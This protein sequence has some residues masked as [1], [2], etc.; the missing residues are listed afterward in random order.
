M[1]GHKTLKNKKKKIY[2]I[3]PNNID[4]STFFNDLNYILKSK[5]ISFF[6]LRLKN[7]KSKKI[8]KYAFKIRKLCQK[9]NVKF[10]INDDPEMSKNIGADGCHIGQR[11]LGINSA[12]KILG[13]KKIL[14]ITCHNSIRLVKKAISHKG[15]VD[16]IAIGAFFKSRTKK[17]KYFAKIE[18][19]KEIRK[20]TK[21]PIVAIG[22]I[23]SKNYKT[24]LLNKVDFLAISGDIWKNKKLKPKD[25]I[26]KFL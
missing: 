18:I 4:S 7:Q 15:K 2:L 24:L 13:K 16:Y 8:F 6:Q 20:F 1:N 17:V 10:I 14:G 5:K 22:G 9:Y 25:A 12:R 26:K 23:N 3:S 21:I 19:I 11:D